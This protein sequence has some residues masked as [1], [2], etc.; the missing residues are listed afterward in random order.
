MQR[1]Y[2]INVCMLH[3]HHTQ[4]QAHDNFVKA[5]TKQLIAN[6]TLHALMSF[7]HLII[8]ESF[9]QGKDVR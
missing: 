7:C 9:L 5:L 6:F 4:A 3:S 8:I 2:A 1:R